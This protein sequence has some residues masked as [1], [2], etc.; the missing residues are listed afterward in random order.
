VE[1]GRS[2]KRSRYDLGSGVVEALKIV[3][4]NE[5]SWEDL[6]SVFGT[7]LPSLGLRR[8]ICLKTVVMFGAMPLS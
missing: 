6:Q 4:A 3:P 2:R 8:R 7:N 5:A 1:A